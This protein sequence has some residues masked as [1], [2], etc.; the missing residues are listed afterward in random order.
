MIATR[1]EMIDLWICVTTLLCLAAFHLSSSIGSGENGM[2]V[3]DRSFV[4]LSNG[5][6][7]WLCGML[8]IAYQR[9]KSVSR[10]QSILDDV[11][12]S[13]GLEVVMVVDEAGTITLS[14]DA[15]TPV[16]GYEID[17]II[18]RNISLLFH[19]IE[20][21]SAEGQAMEDALD[22]IGFYRGETDG[23]TK[24]N[25]ALTLEVS[26]ALRKKGDGRVLMIQDIT[27]RK[28]AEERLRTAKE[29]AEEATRAKEEALTKLEASYHRLSELE[30]HRDNLIQM[31]CH[32]MKAPLQ[33]LILQ[34]DILKDLV[35]EKLDND[36]LESVDT[37]LAYSR[38][39]ELMVHSM[40]DL[41]KLESGKLPMKI[42]LGNITGVVS[43]SLRFVRSM[44]GDFTLV[45]DDVANERSI[46]FDHA[47]VQRVLVNLLYN[48]V[49]YSPSR[50]TI[51]VV[52]QDQ[53]DGVRL[54]V[55]D[56]GPGIPEEFQERIFDKFGQV[57]GTT[58]ERSGST[59]LGLTFCKMA[60]EAH[61]GSIGVNSEVGKGSTFWFC[62]PNQGANKQLA[63]SPIASTDHVLATGAA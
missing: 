13:T 16:F 2:L 12:S 37:L 63:R 34:L 54:S 9:W 25:D 56:E 40:L 55:S 19:P 49:K 22:R 50:G 8:W 35:L 31:V 36:E 10:E 17:E 20:P 18:G 27:E 61:G 6:F 26:T 46:A 51:R 1:R 42:Q 60:V 47:I 45:L 43:K 7:L 52:I 5:L 33:V 53:A 38:Q 23:I 24:H 44:A 3:Q 4:T 30:I 11:M 32:D 39:L 48:A 59:G 14:N 15:L 21:Q 57:K 29:Q 28:H 41:S 58:Y 62:L